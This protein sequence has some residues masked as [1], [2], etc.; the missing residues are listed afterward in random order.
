MSDKKRVQ[1]DS[2]KNTVH[3][4]YSSHEYDRHQIDSVLYQKCY[5]M[6]SPSEWCEIISELNKYK[7]VEML[8]HKR[9][10]S[11]LRLN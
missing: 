2:S 8:V 11:N 6:I 10:T 1:F 5:N 4:T 9:S 3:E 7:L